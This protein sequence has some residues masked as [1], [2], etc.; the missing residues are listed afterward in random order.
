M[1]KYLDNDAA[2]MTG[3]MDLG[4]EL[5][6]LDEYRQWLADSFFSTV[7]SESQKFLHGLWRRVDGEFCNVSYQAKNLEGG[8]YL[9]RNEDGTCTAGIFEELFLDEFDDISQSTNVAEPSPEPF[10]HDAQSITSTTSNHTSIQNPVPFANE[11]DAARPW[12]TASSSL[13]SSTDS[14]PLA[15]RL[16]SPL[17]NTILQRNREE[18]ED[19]N[20]SSH[21]RFRCRLAL[22]FIGESE[23]AVWQASSVTYAPWKKEGL[24]RCWY[25]AGFCSWHLLRI[26]KYRKERKE[27]G[28]SLMI[29][30]RSTRLGYME[31]V[32]FPTVRVHF[33]M[34]PPDFSKW[35]ISTKDL[36]ASIVEGPLRHKL[37][38]DSASR[39]VKR[40]YRVLYA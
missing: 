32:A 34:T 7:D 10:G 9:V 17:T 6:I 16:T 24:G 23:H 18:G 3:V 4:T 29:M 2:R 12:I 20:T 14:R 31:M 19:C 25:E 11:E 39:L 28:E 35:G 15:R 37:N 5:G 40:I 1:L 36:T 38:L 26:L 8:V 30:Y 33:M 13:S 21:V 27:R 22:Q